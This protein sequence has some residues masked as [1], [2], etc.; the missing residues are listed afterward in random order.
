MIVSP[1]SAPLRR[2]KSDMIDPW[3]AGRDPRGQ[4]TCG[5]GTSTPTASFTEKYCTPAE[6]SASR[7]TGALFTASEASDEA[8][9]SD[10]RPVADDVARPPA[11]RTRSTNL[12]IPEAK[13]D[14]L[15]PP[16]SCEFPP[17]IGATP[18]FFLAQLKHMLFI[19]HF[20]LSKLCLRKV[21]ATSL[22][23]A[24]QKHRS[25]FQKSGVDYGIMWFLSFQWS[26][27]GW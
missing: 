24:G 5:G 19:F 11:V 8:A 17:G 21:P 13:R 27:T 18:L 1:L 4:G 23:M 10:P 22:M 3:S 26:G 9:P 15:L 12:S 2:R 14:W 7:F 25:R 6:S 16:C 20:S